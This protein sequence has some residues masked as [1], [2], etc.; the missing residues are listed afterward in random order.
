MSVPE[1]FK[2]PPELSIPPKRGY[3]E[4]FDWTLNPRNYISRL[5][6]SYKIYKKIN[7]SEPP[8]LTSEELEIMFPDEYRE[9]KESLKNQSPEAQEYYLFQVL[10]A[11]WVENPIPRPILLEETIDSGEYDYIV[12]DMFQEAFVKGDFDVYKKLLKDFQI[13][14][15]KSFK[16]AESWNLENGDELKNL[17]NLDDNELNIWIHTYHKN[18]DYC[19]TKS[20][21]KLYGRIYD[22]AFENSYYTRLAWYA[23]SSIHPYNVVLDELQMSERNKVL[24]TAALKLGMSL[25]Q[26]KYS[27]GRFASSK[28]SIKTKFIDFD[29]TPWEPGI[30]HYTRK[31]Q[32]ITDNGDRVRTGYV[33]P[34]A[35]VQ[36]EILA[37]TIDSFF[38][39]NALNKQNK[40]RYSALQDQLEKLQNQIEFVDDSSFTV[41]T[42]CNITSTY[43][44]DNPYDI[45]NEDELELLKKINEANR[46]NELTIQDVQNLISSGCG[47]DLSGNC[48]LPCVKDV[49][50]ICVKPITQNCTTD[51]SGNCKLPCIYDISKKKCVNPSSTNKSLIKTI[52]DTW[53]KYKILLIIF[54]VF[55]VLLLLI[56]PLISIL[57]LILSILFFFI[58]DQEYID[59]VMAILDK[60]TNILNK[61][62]ANPKKKSPTTQ[63]CTKDSSGKCSPGCKID[64]SG[65]CVKT[66]L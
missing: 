61:V 18:F 58:A 44:T 54:I 36:Y 5:E 51:L 17:M 43:Q 12:N 64:S 25:K 2:I 55:L 28:S 23:D 26:Y 15:K 19:T 4:E 63:I 48:K 45:N 1:G 56:N 66:V 57:V 50:N 47:R 30:E 31:I 13:A 16:I 22:P 32:G 60:I 21:L 52:T 14:Q 42:I 46:L 41:T 20:N 65:N 10:W 33:W 6:L 35:N 24:A 9:V 29:G 53:N 38:D 7:N 11:H 39:N 49:S 37:K 8:P 3:Y 27:W 62:T 40:I 34:N 59:A